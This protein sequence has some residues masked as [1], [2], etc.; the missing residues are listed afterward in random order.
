MNI[1]VTRP[2]SYGL[3]QSGASRGKI[4][5]VSPSS[6]VT[7]AALRERLQ[8]QLG[9]AYVIN[10]ELGGGGSSRVFLATETALDR[11]VVLKVLPPELTDGVDSA[12]FRREVLIAAR[13]QHPH[14]VPLLTA[15]DGVAADAEN[16]LRWYTMPYVEG[17]SLREWL[18]KRGAFPIPD[19]S[20]LL[21]ELATAL[22]YAHAKGVIHRDIKPENILMCEGVSMIS[23]F[24]VAMALDDASADAVSTGRRVTTVSR[25]L[26]TP[27]YMA[28]EQVNNAR[29]V[30]H[31]A[32]LYA[33]ACVAYEV[34]TGAPPFVRP[35]LRATLSAQLSE[36]PTPLSERRRDLPASLAD[37]LTRCLAKDPLQRP[38]SATAIIKVL[39]GLSSPAVAPDV[40]P[41]PPEHNERAQSPALPRTMVLVAALLVGVVAWWVMGL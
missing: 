35:T 15:D 36:Q 7:D 14:L 27:A 16:A 31:K 12:R 22:A 23:D 32:D 2:Q 30:D 4:P 17:Q 19:A 41:T 40:E 24:G 33:F 39:D 3:Q 18:N 29:V 10:R 11:P 25:A 1:T 21:R 9:D 37:I 38:H 8:R 13:L 34:I 6:S 28:P 5:V 20:R 26:G